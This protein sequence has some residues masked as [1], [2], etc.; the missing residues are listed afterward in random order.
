MPCVSIHGA[1]SYCSSLPPCSEVMMQ[2]VT[3][4]GPI[5]FVFGL[6]M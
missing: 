3:L 1:S 2:Q 5:M 6:L 4:I